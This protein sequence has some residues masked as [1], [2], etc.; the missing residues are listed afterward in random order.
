[1][2]KAPQNGY[3]LL[4]LLLFISL[5]VIA[6]A[7]AAPTI[8]FE[9]KRD[10]EMEMIHRGV[11]YTRAIRAFTK[12][13]ARYPLRLEELQSTDS[14]RF[15]RKLYKDPITGKDFRLLHVSDIHPDTAPLQNSTGSQGNS[16]PNAADSVNPSNAS[17]DQT[18]QAA[19]TLGLAATPNPAGQQNPFGQSPFG[20]NA[21]GRNSQSNNNDSFGG[22]VILGVAS[23]SKARSIR[24][25]DK[26]RHY[27]EWFFFYDPGY[28][29]GQV[30]NGPTSLTPPAQPINGAAP[31]N[32]Q[33]QQPTAAAPQAQ[34]SNQ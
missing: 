18:T 9:I 1:M 19:N 22:G 20:Q 26:K 12:T 30:I 2:N 4:T 14:R 15:I 5:M 34:P 23:Q 7:V 32:P 8:A 33:A 6:A 28:D 16:N 10:R 11:Q 27:N 21:A 24:E 3:V 31:A 29:R 17:G 25:F 13:T